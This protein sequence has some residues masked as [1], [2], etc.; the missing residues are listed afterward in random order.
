M[1]ISDKINI[2]ELVEWLAYASVPAFIVNKYREDETVRKLSQNNPVEMLTDEFNILTEQSQKPIEDLATAY[3]ILVS[4][5]FLDKQKAVE[6]FSSVNLLRLKWGERIKELYLERYV[7][8]DVHISISSQRPIRSK[9]KRRISSVDFSQSRRNKIPTSKTTHTYEGSIV[10]S[11]VAV[12]EIRTYTI[13][14]ELNT[15]VAA[16]IQG[17][18]AGFVQSSNLPSG[19]FYIVPQSNN[20]S[21]RLNKLTY[22]VLTA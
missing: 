16:L 14:V 21:A 7:K 12:S 5:T 15:P 11:L 20:I 6:A 13:R 9:S 10:R 22:K 4:F 8:D 18:I 2:N 1:K 17:G 19:T 3:A